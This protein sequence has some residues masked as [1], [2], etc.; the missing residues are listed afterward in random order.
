MHGLANCARLD[1]ALC[2][3]QL[4]LAVALPQSMRSIFMQGFVMY[5]TLILFI[6]I[7]LFDIALHYNMLNLLHIYEMQWPCKLRQTRLCNSSWLLLLIP[8]TKVHFYAR[9]CNILHSAL[10]QLLKVKCN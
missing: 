10:L 6:A 8:H 1:C 5:C 7:S 3:V 9:I 4:I 2:S